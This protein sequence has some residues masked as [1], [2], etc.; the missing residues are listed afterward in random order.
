VPRNSTGETPGGITKH[1]DLAFE[2]WWQ[3]QDFSDDATQREV[4]IAVRA[5]NACWD[6][7]RAFHADAEELRS[8]AEEQ[9]KD[10]F[11]TR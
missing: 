9:Y 2:F 7:T 11:S 10:I 1:R 5:W 3:Y 4:D 6:I 8:R